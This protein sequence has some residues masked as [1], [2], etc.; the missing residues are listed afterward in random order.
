[1]NTRLLLLTDRAQLAPGR[2]LSR[3]V[4][5]CADAG[6]TT[7]VVREH[8]LPARDRQALLAR[9]ATVAGLTVISSRLSDPSADGLHLAAHQP[10]AEGWF[11]RSC[12]G[13]DDVRRAA[14]EG[15][16]WATLSPYGA[17]ASKPGHGPALSSDAFAEDTG[18]PVFALGGIAADNAR[19][20]LGRG[21]YG[22][23]VMGAVMRAERPARVVERLLGALA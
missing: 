18:I 6:L 20:A 19:E 12:H 3:T 22:V 10:S 5:E 2:S 1:M 16:S 7:V 21:A 9:L 13:T 4:E 17:S 8:D 11:G 14:A 23:A 15:A